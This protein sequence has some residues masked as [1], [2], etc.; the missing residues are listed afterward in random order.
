[1]VVNATNKVSSVLIII[2]TM[3]PKTVLG[4]KQEVMNNYD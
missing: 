1:M 3:P 4:L 2:A